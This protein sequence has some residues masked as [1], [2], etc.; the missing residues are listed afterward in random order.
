[1]VT[2]PRPVVQILDPACRRKVHRGRTYRPL[3][4][5]TKQDPAVLRCFWIAGF[6]SKASATAISVKSSGGGSNTMWYNAERP[7]LAALDW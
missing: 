7:Q 5:I 2:L 6:N 3:L 1:M 4:P